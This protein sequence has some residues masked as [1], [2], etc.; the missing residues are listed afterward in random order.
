[1]GWLDAAIDMGKSVLKDNA[2]AIASGVA[3]AVLGSGPSKGPSNATSSITSV[4]AWMSDYAKQ[5]LT[6]AN[7]VATQ[8]Y[9]QYGGPR[10]AGLTQ[11]QQDAANIVRSNTGQAA[12]VVTDAMGRLD[13][14]AGKGML[15]RA[16][17]YLDGA[18]G[19]YTDP[20]VAEKFMNPYNQNVIDKSKN[21][22][23]RMW[24]DQIMPG[25]ESMFVRNGNYGSSAHA[26]VA[27]RNATDLT[28][29]LQENAGAMLA[30]SYNTGAGQ[31]N[32]EQN[33]Q[34]QLAQIASSLGQT[35][36][37]MNESNVNNQA[38]LAQQWQAMQSADADALDAI[39]TREQNMNQGAMDIDFQN[40]G[41][42]QGYSKEQLDYLQQYLSG[43]S[44]NVDKSTSGTSSSTTNT[45]PLQAASQGLGIYKTLQEMMSKNPAPSSSPK[46]PPELAG[47]YV[48]T[49]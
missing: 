4:P 48:D 11:D 19:S 49:P 32:N 7:T 23:M 29:R 2:G 8:P 33:Q 20:G 1:M 44:G 43:L 41:A 17:R 24:D 22:A 5:L 46:T 3:G 6:Q 30:D 16:G 36:Q 31:F 28:S 40:W 34:G 37:S 14:N 25:M 35:E 12:G 15:T 10:I 38:A 9:Q 13:P 45:S 26:R 47:G 39:G 42:A 27:G 18:G 21:E